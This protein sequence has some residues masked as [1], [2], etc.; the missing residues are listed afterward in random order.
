M[1]PSPTFLAAWISV[2]GGMT[3]ICICMNVQLARKTGRE[4]DLH[5]VYK[6]MDV[7]HDVIGTCGVMD[8]SHSHS[9]SHSH[10][11]RKLMNLA[12]QFEEIV[13]PPERHR[14]VLAGTNTVR[15]LPLF[16]LEIIEW[17]MLRVFCVCLFSACV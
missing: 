9:H 5:V 14:E 3:F 13:S 2:F 6:L 17:R 7:G 8:D 15:S 1:V 12:E 11:G 4:E 10:A 16:C